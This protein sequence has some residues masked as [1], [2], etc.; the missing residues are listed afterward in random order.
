MGYS[1]TKDVDKSYFRG[2][3]SVQLRE[4]RAASQDLLLHDKRIIPPASHLPMDTS[5]D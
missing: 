3:V 5:C 4:A 2:H 1:A